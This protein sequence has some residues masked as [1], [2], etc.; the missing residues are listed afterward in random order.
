[1]TIL[2]QMTRSRLAPVALG[3]LFAVA[4]AGCPGDRDEPAEPEAPSAEDEAPEEDPEEEAAA[5]EEE[6]PETAEAG[7]LAPPFTLP[8]AD[9]ETYALEDFRGQHVILEWINHDCPFVRK[10]YDVGEMQQLQATYTDPDGAGAAWLSIASSGPGQQGHE[11][12][13]RWLEL[14][15][16]KEAAPTAV[17]ID[18]EGEVGQR[19]GARTTPQMV[20]IDP[21]GVLIYNGAI[22]SI[23]SR[24]SDDIEEADNYVEMVMDALLAGEEAPLSYSDPYG[25][26]V[27]YGPAE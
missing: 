23:S 3:A 18:E 9:G 21:E 2:K 20:V 19:Y 13:E 26:S 6:A 11:T 16:E 12:P 10:F 4:A 25:C 14:T 7:K 15:E 27:H 17:L 22:D 1:M 8:G 5:A 24:D